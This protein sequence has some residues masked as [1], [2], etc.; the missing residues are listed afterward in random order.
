MQRTY[1]QSQTLGKDV[2]R[3]P[4]LLKLQ[5]NV[6]N[7]ELYADKEEILSFT[8]SVQNG[9][10]IFRSLLRLGGVDMLQFGVLFRV[11]Y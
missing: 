1:T 7:P 2:F 5:I 11:I 9:D 6:Q 10:S 3:F 8:I 4:F